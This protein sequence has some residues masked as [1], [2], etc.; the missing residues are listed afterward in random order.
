[1]DVLPYGHSCAVTSSGN[2]KCW[3]ENS[4]GQLGNG[5]AINQYAPVDVAGCCFVH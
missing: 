2:M 5:T 4:S 3:G 1:M